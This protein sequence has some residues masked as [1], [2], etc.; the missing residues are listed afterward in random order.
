[1]KPLKSAIM[2]AA[3]AVLGTGNA[4]A[5]TQQQ[6]YGSQLMTRQERIDYRNQMRLLKTEEERIAFRAEHHKKM[7]ERAK[8]RGVTL[9]ETPPARGAG[10][11]PGMGGMGPGMGGMG[12]RR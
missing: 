2:I 3:F 7:Q 9:P 4:A 8:E 1:M 12:G 11:G 10:M 6:V 5:E